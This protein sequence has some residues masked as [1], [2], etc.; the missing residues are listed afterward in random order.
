MPGM[1]LAGDVGPIQGSTQKNATKGQQMSQGAFSP[2][3]ITHVISAI[4]DNYGFSK[5]EFIL[6]RLPVNEKP[7][8][9]V[10]QYVTIEGDVSEAYRVTVPNT[11]PSFWRWPRP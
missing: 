8:V 9:I 4:M 11:P 1:V 10:V 5:I 6:A 2:S 3:P 7:L